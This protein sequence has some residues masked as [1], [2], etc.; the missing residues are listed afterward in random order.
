MFLHFFIVTT[1]LI[2]ICILF[3]YTCR[4]EKHNTSRF[5]RFLS[6]VQN[7]ILPVTT[8]VQPQSMNSFFDLFTDYNDNAGAV[9]KK[10]EGLMYDEQEQAWKNDEENQAQKQYDEHKKLQ[11]Q[12]YD[13]LL[14]DTDDTLMR[15]YTPVK[16]NVTDLNTYLARDYTTLPTNRLINS[17][18]RINTSPKG[19]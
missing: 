10:P 13:K 8:A 4:Y 19:W 3:T 1:V 16:C 2:Y 18:Y 17:K 7:P 11:V 9:L 6:S 15:F 12:V 5:L 14:N